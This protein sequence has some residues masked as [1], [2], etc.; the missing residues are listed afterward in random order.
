M[1]RLWGFLSIGVQN[2]EYKPLRVICGLLVEISNL[3]FKQ[4][5]LTISKIIGWKCYFEFESYFHSYV[6]CLQVAWFSAKKFSMP[7]EISA[8]SL[9]L[10]FLRVTRKWLSKVWKNKL[11][12]GFETCSNLRLG[13]CLTRVRRLNR[14]GCCDTTPDRCQEGSGFTILFRISSNASLSSKLRVGGIP[15]PEAYHE[16]NYAQRRR[17]RQNSL[18]N[19]DFRLSASTNPKQSSLFFNYSTFKQH[20]SNSIF[21]PPLFQISLFNFNLRA[22]FARL[23]NF[24]LLW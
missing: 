24:K 10:K 9:V 17:L 3:N 21:D 11:K 23:F 8:C 15:G 16:E 7:S 19:E 14:K 13:T 1:P 4:K 20:S 18:P 22:S 5:F 12:I 6:W 2:T